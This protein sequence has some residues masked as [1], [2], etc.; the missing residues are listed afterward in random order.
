MLSPDAVSLWTKGGAAGT[1]DCAHLQP[2]GEAST[3]LNN[4]LIGGHGAVYGRND[5]GHL[6]DPHTAGSYDR[7]VT[8]IGVRR[9]QKWKVYTQKLGTLRSMSI[10]SVHQLYP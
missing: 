10:R 5:Y 3:A 6:S 4:R 1:I 8:I 2:N 9:N 7:T